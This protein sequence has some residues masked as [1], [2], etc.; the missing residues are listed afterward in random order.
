MAAAAVAA[1]APAPQPLGTVG[2]TDTHAL[3]GER[4]GE[5]WKA[6]RLELERG[7]E[8][9]MSGWEA[10]RAREAAAAA[11]PLNALKRVLVR[12][13]AVS[14]DG[15][16]FLPLP[17]VVKNGPVEPQ[18]AWAPGALP[19]GI[20]VE[21]N[22]QKVV[23]CTLGKALV[24]QGTEKSFTTRERAMAYP[25]GVIKPLENP[26]AVGPPEKWGP[27]VFVATH[28]LHLEMTLQ[29]SVD[30]GERGSAAGL[31]PAV[32]E[33]GF[34]MRLLI[35]EEEDVLDKWAPGHPDLAVVLGED[36]EA[37]RGA[38][39]FFKAYSCAMSRGADYRPTW[40]HSQRTS[41]QGVVHGAEK[42][43]ALDL[44]PAEVAFDAGEG[45]D[46]L[47]YG[48]HSPFLRDNVLDA[49]EDPGDNVYSR[50]DRGEA[51][52][53]KTVEGMMEWIS[54]KL[55]RKGRVV[56]K[57]LR[58]LAEVMVR[59]RAVLLDPR[60]SQL[61]PPLVARVAASAL[62]TKEGLRRHVPAE[63]LPGLNDE[64][65]KL[66]AHGMVEE[67]EAAPDGRPPEDLWINGLVVTM[68]R[69]PPGSPPGT[70]RKVR[71]CLDSKPAN[72]AAT[73][74]CTTQLPNLEEH[75]G[76]TDGQSLFSCL[77]SPNAYH[78]FRLDDASSK[79]FG[80]TLRDDKTGRNRYYKFRGAPFG[81][82]DFPA[83]FSER[84]L[85]V[86]E[87][88]HG[89]DLSTCRAF[90]DDVIV[91]TG[92]ARM[93]LQDAWGTKHEEEI[94]QAHLRCLER[95]LE[96][97]V[98]HGLTINL[99]KSDILQEE[100]SVCGI[101]TNGQERRLDPARQDGWDNLGRPKRVTLV[102]LQHVLGVAN[103]V[104]PFLPVDYMIKSEPLFALAREAS[105]AAAAAGTDKAALRKARELPDSLW[106]TAHDE[107]LAWVIHQ[108][109]HSQTR[110]FLDYSKKVHV[111]ADS[112]DLG[113]AA[114]I[115]QYQEDGSFRIAYTMAKRFTSQQKL[116]SVGAREVY[117]WL[118]AMRRWHK[119][120]A[121]A[122]CV[123]VS[124]HHNLVTSALDMENTALKRWVLELSQWDGFV[125]H[126]VHRRGE[127]NLVCDH[128]SRFACSTG[129][130]AQEDAPPAF[131]PLLRALV[132]KTQARAGSAAA[133][134][135]PPPTTTT[136]TPSGAPLGG[137]HP[138][139]G[140]SGEQPLSPP[141]A[142]AQAARGGG[143][144]APQ[145]AQAPGSRAA[146]AEAARETVTV[147]T[148]AT[149]KRE[150]GKRGARAGP[151][152]QRRA[153]AVASALLRAD[154]TSVPPPVLVE[155]VN[156]HEHTLSPFMENILAAQQRMTEEDIKAYLAQPQFS[157][158]KTSW[159]GRDVYMA[160]GRILVPEKEVKLLT[161]IFEVL[162][163]KNMHASPVLV[164]D[165]MLRARL[166]V[167]N[168]GKHF[169]AYY[170]ACTCQHARAPK[171]LRKHGPLLV[172]PRYWPLSH[173][174]M[175]FA[176]LPV[177]EH[178]G[179]SYKGALLVVDAC[180]RVCQF[181]PVVDMTAETA[182]AALERWSCTWG[183][184]AM[185]H[186]DQGSHFTGGVFKD[187][188]ARHGVAQDLGTPHHSR[189]RGVVERL[190]G[191][192]KEG[193]KRLLPQGRA[194]EWPRVVAELERRVNRM[195]HRGLGGVAPFDYLIRGHR[196]LS[197]HLGPLAL[198]VT[199]VDTPQT[200]EDL[201]FVLESIRQVADWCG[202]ID[203]VRRALESQ[204][205]YKEFTAGVGD[206]VL[207]YVGERE[208]S[209]H[210]F[211]QGP[212]KVTQVGGNGFYQVCELLA[213]DNLGV[214]VECHASRLIHFNGSRTSGTAEHVRKLDGE[215]FVV[216]SVLDGPREPDGRFLVKWLGVA[217]PRWEAQS[218][219]LRA[220]LKFKAYCA[221][222]K[223]TLMGKPLPTA[224][225]G[226]PV[227]VRSSRARGASE[228]G[229]CGQ[230]TGFTIL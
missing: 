206:L 75:V 82:R 184:P 3:D 31:K 37:A 159:N 55:Q 89:C 227:L 139:N 121:F 135:P 220:V 221:E 180:S 62:P 2:S 146:A 154:G 10:Q 214:P 142:A 106:T 207:R 99:A 123:F 1:R 173:V 27:P 42:S 66:L 193:L 60:P 186:T 20:T 212:F 163:D 32:R 85:E 185:V 224:V 84:M 145:D 50:K 70:K 223:M 124:D 41:L 90:L 58:Q 199:F 144:G 161:E 6:V 143:Q 111:V 128:L 5:R 74:W 192:L 156:P 26:V 8:E 125:R 190:V 209:L 134:P 45:A 150:R 141:A 130:T 164:Q 197:D 122:D 7:E 201:T 129:L 51:L 179:K 109:Q 49:V 171:Q 217:E 97:Y 176:Y 80:F 38:V 92:V 43:L 11:V 157:V 168:F 172:G 219:E 17:A 205:V 215:H 56:D 181:T 39:E 71:M 162:H 46:P 187:Y 177:T 77:D 200:E 158:S 198:G 140:V 59:Q 95:T 19:L 93:R 216:E 152:A 222:K 174:F 102:Y 226:R 4:G 52:L 147:P 218:S 25:G 138:G 81:F 175:D 116:W 118:M 151:K 194:L 213:E 107:A 64:V 33:C 86:I 23:Y 101:I 72:K 98:R 169:D 191:K 67:V 44:A 9:W 18:A 167:P 208:N 36:A 94:V 63:A 127:Q 78:Q 73:A 228:E 114:C 196:Q 28:E 22:V 57:Y 113:T 103:Y 104:A 126:R 83:L 119:E 182:A 211:Y 108:I 15:K 120:L 61:S 149:A 96:G 30:L 47:P 91:G 153:A 88:A 229:V 131:S 34:A 178:G 133:P 117:G 14:R 53:P 76:S 21:G 230:V 24:D 100:V 136:T 54:G 87:G 48:P 188:L 69:L 115:G 170:A 40:T 210:P 195:P 160:K 166:F 29:W 148:A 12:R 165:S 155:F 112:S 35:C 202:E 16:G 204:D 105:R 68:R 110:V 203:A 137:A 132:R 189:G 183:F 65:R 225:R 13:V 79:L